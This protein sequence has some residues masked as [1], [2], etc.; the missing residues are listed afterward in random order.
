MREAMG[1]WG[2]Y[3]RDGDLAVRRIFGSLGP[4]SYGGPEGGQEGIVMLIPKMGWLAKMREARRVGTPV[5]ALETPDPIDATKGIADSFGDDDPIIRWDCVMG[6]SGYNETGRDTVAEIPLDQYQAMNLIEVLRAMSKVN[7]ENLILMIPLAHRFLDEPAVIQGILNLRDLWKAL[8]STLI[9]MVQP[10]TRLPSELTQDAMGIEAG[11]PGPDDLLGVVEGISGAA[12]EQLGKADPGDEAKRRAAESLV[13]LTAF[14]AESACAL[15]VNDGGL[16]PEVLWE[17][18]RGMVNQTPGLQL[19]P[20]GVETFDVVGGMENIRNFAGRLF[21]RVDITSAGA[22]PRSSPRLIVWIDEIEKA[23]AG[24]GGSSG[25]G[26]TSGTSQDQLQVL[27]NH[28]QENSW[29]GMILVGPPGSG[30]SMVAKAIGASHGIPTV[31]LDLGA[32]K[33]SLVGQSEQRIRAAMRI[34]GALAGNQALWVATCNKLDS[35][36][37]ELRRRFK[38]GIWFSDLPSPEEQ[39]QIWKIHLAKNGFEDGDRPV[40]D[41]PW[42]GAEIRSCCELARTLGIKP[43]G[44]SGYIVPVSRSDPEGIERLR[45]AAHGRFLSVSRPGEYRMPRQ[46]KDGLGRKLS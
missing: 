34:I 11:L 39:A 25:I 29:T 23:M 19:V 15:A 41:S 28:M 45:K 9:L 20:P 14:A 12:E 40:M 43:V 2:M 8:G 1:I 30:K 3:S 24:T 13:G 4:V 26:D 16:L 7:T 36:P 44:A 37:P 10:G 33:G 22:S 32:L 5:I 17:R 21:N 38:Y 18:K 46:E 27:L 42:T 35:V 6:L 31:M